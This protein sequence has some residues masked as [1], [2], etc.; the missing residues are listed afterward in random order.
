[1]NRTNSTSATSAEKITL[2]DYLRVRTRF[3]IDP[4]VTLLARYRLPP[5]AL[6]V[7]GMLAHFL[8]AWLIANG[9]MQLA[10]V[11]IAV[12]SPL[13]ALDG[14]LARKLGRKQGGF[15]AFLDSTLDRL[16]EI[17]LFGGFIWYY[18]QQGDTLMLA[19]SYITV[20]GSLLVSYTRARAES[21]GL[22]A[23]VGVLSRVE[24]Y[25]VLTAF[26]VLN[27]PYIALVI[28]A[29]LTYVTVFQRMFHVWQQSAQADHE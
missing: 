25:V 5:D 23:K 26:L 27:R 17:I 18:T 11:A 10:A 1:M 7:I 29:V 20:T 2:T 28:M 3:I 16:A 22:S 15:G 9:Q 4:I 13:D 21:L 14:A 19:M 8:F 6:T 24:R 12:I